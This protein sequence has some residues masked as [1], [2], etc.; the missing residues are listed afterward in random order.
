MQHIEQDNRHCRQK[1]ATGKTP[2]KEANAGR[3]QQQ[4]QRRARYRDDSFDA[5]DSHCKRDQTRAPPSY[6]ESLA[7]SLHSRG[8]NHSPVAAALHQLNGQWDKV[9]QVET[10]QPMEWGSC[11]GMRAFEHASKRKV[12]IRAGLCRPRDAISASTA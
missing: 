6:E 5:E 1:V 2:I 4:S 8:T 11:E 9:D 3:R 12:A 7:N 10:V